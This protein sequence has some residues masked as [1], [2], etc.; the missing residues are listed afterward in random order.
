MKRILFVVLVLA[1][2]F[3][4]ACEQKNTTT[5]Q[6]EQGNVVI[7]E[8]SQ[9]AK[10]WCPAGGQW[11]YAANVEQGAATGEW[12]VLGLETSGKYAGLCHVKYTLKQGAQTIDM[13]YWF[14]EDGESGYVQMDV[15]GQKITQE[16]HKS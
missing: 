9:G 15:N 3:L 8:E 14:T 4:A 10:G 13:E 7:S 11:K 2:V 6:T 16:W 1:L 12:K 5:L